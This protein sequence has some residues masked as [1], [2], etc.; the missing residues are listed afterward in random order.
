MS[1]NTCNTERY[2]VQPKKVPVFSAEELTAWFKLY[3]QKDLCNR[4]VHTEFAECLCISREEA[5][6][7]AHQIT[8]FAKRGVENLGYGG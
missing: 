7:L 2:K 8:H 5:K 6:T 1:L 3:C 4:D